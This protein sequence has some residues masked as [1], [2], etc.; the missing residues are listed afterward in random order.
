MC[1][2][3]KRNS[4][5]AHGL[6]STQTLKQALSVIKNNTCR[7]LLEILSLT[8]LCYFNVLKWAYGYRTPS[9]SISLLLSAMRARMVNNAVPL[10]IS[11]E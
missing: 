3:E 1:Q 5:Y 9:L 8:P 10:M 4:G 2:S 11:S 7:S 6:L